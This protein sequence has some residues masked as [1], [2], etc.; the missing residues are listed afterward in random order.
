MRRQ[1]HVL[2]WKRPAHEYAGKVFSKDIQ[3]HFP[4]RR[5]AMS[6]RIALS[7]A[8]SCALLLNAC[9]GSDAPTTATN[10]QPKASDTAFVQSFFP[11]AT[12]TVQAMLATSH[13]PPL[14]MQ[15]ELIV[16]ALSIA[17]DSVSKTATVQSRTSRCE[18]A[19]TTCTDTLALTSLIPSLISGIF[20]LSSALDNTTAS[21]VRNVVV[22]TTVT[23]QG[24]K[25]AA[26]FYSCTSTGT[27]YSL[28]YGFY[29]N[30]L[31]AAYTY[32]RNGD[33]R[34]SSS[35]WQRYSALKIGSVDVDTAQIHAIVDS[36]RTSRM[37][38]WIEPAL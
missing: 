28:Y 30:G 15:D 10:G 9:N 23:L 29:L 33:T 32:E 36:I 27:G 5:L 19:S 18:I 17:W 16:E 4:Q 34:Q 11:A 22:D 7:L 2:W 6:R 38:P 14:A 12:G 21:R 26:K 13:R 25:I 37:I 20:P 3:F 1:S 24:R 35:S 31:G 8:C